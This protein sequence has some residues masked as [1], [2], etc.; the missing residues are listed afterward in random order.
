M[1]AALLERR[2]PQTALHLGADPCHKTIADFLAAI[3]RRRNLA[4]PSPRGWR[5]FQSTVNYLTLERRKIWE[6]YFAKLNAAT[7]RRCKCA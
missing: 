6:P 4:E 3:E 7:Q 5:S 1:S 2:M